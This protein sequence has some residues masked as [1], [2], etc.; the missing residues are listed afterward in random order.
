MRNV[1]GSEG[2]YWMFKILVTI[3]LAIVTI[4]FLWT[5]Y[6]MLINIP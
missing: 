4:I 2:A 6:S 1:K 3:V 5:I